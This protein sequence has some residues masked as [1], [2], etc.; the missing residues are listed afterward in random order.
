MH[1]VA[2][3]L[4]NRNYRILQQVIVERIFVQVP[5]QLTAIQSWKITSVKQCRRDKW[6]SFGI[7]GKY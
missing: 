2:G 1:D 3:K 4:Y 5:K 7:D 6:Q